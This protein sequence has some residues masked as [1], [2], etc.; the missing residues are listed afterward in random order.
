MERLETQIATMTT[1]DLGIGRPNIKST[2]AG[3]AEL[4]QAAEQ[5]E[6]MFVR[7][8]LEQ[9]HKSELA[10]GLFSTS[11]DDAFQSML[12]NEYAQNIAGKVNLG[13]ADVLYEQFA[14]TLPKDVT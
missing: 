11:K 5:F 2:N 12:D 6:A 7:Q 9:S 1:S 13:L 4:R 10:E 8:I 14:A 3:R